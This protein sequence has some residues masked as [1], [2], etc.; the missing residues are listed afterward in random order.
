MHRG[1]RSSGHGL[2][3][4]V[5]GK[6]LARGLGG[7]AAGTTQAVDVANHI[8][9]IDS[10]LPAFTVITTPTPIQRRAFDLLGA[11]HRLGYV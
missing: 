3:L 10:D 9:P 6:V 5:Y 11:S 4:N 1:W 2:Q 8:Q 7:P